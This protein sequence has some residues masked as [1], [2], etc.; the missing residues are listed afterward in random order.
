M[1]RFR[2]WAPKADKIRVAVGGQKHSLR[3]VE[4]GWWEAD[5]EQAKPGTDYAY[6][7]DDEDLALPD[8]RSEWQPEGVHGPS[9]LIDHR[10]FRWTDWAWNPPPLASAIIYE[11]H[12]GTFTPEGTF[13]AAIGKLDALKD[14]GITHIELLPVNSFPGTRGWGYDGVDLFAPQESY[15]GP[16]G[17]KRLVDAC[18][19]KGLGVLMDVVYNHFGPSGNY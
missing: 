6:F 11:L 16:E 10:A 14:L 13:D 2:G 8:P 12:I 9:R 18:H 5:V 19:A 7:I 17:L 3:K 4:D 15:G 1:H